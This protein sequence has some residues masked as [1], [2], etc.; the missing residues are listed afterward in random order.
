[1]GNLCTGVGAKKKALTEWMDRWMDGSKIGKKGKKKNSTR[2]RKKGR[3]R[4]NDHGTDGFGIWEKK[5]GA[6][7]SP[8]SL[9]FVLLT[10]NVSL[11]LCVPGIPFTFCTRVY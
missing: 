2:E 4:Q 10:V 7:D 8:P 9:L 11:Y 5:I 1:V 6:D 3:K